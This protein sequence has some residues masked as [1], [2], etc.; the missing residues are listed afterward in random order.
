[1]H[2]RQR[3]TLVVGSPTSMSAAGYAQHCSPSLVSAPA[4]RVHFVH[5]ASLLRR[6]AGP[7]VRIIRGWVTRDRRKQGHDAGAGGKMSAISPAILTSTGIGT[8][9][10]R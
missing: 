4:L 7:N 1:M 3:F 6:S 8:R 2:N 5:D 9:A 10:L